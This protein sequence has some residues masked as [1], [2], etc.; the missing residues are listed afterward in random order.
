MI[1][2][3]KIY[4]ENTK[5]LIL[6]D[7]DNRDRETYAKELAS[8]LSNHT[9]TILETTH[10][11]AIIRPSK[12]TSIEVN[13]EQNINDGVIPAKEEVKKIDPQED[14]IMDA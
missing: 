10:S 8:L 13:E 12:V 2:I 3:I 11:V 14:V 1:K 9:I 4:Q 7:A 6:K 5:P